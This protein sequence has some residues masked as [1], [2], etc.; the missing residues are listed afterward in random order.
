[1]PGL[2]MACSVGNCALRDSVVCVVVLRA[3]CSVSLDVMGHV[4]VLML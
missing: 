1:M 3:M 2:I 4:V